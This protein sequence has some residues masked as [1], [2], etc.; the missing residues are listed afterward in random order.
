MCKLTNYTFAPSPAVYWKHGKGQGNN[1]IYVTT[2]MLSVAMVQQIVS[3]LGA[4]ETLLICPKK[5]EPGCEK[6]DNRITIK[7][8]PQSILKAC[9]FGKKEYLLPIKERAM[10]EVDE[11]EVDSDEN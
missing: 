11:D 8:I 6:V 9:Q 5:F 4:N 7:K 2:Q 3:H 1:S 10:E